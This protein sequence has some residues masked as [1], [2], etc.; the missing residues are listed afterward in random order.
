[1]TIYRFSVEVGGIDP[2]ED[3]FEDRFYGSGVDDAS[4]CVSNGLICLAFDREASNEEDAI[5]SAMRDIAKRG[6]KVNRI[7]WDD[8]RT[9]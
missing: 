8:P 9:L 5:L 1:M 2:N 6:G 3:G 7:T 4:I